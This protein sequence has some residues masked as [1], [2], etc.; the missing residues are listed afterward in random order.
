[1]HA[2]ACS[3]TDTDTRGDDRGRGREIGREIERA[4]EGVYTGPDKTTQKPWASPRA[5][6]VEQLRMMLPNEDAKKA[7]G[8]HHTGI[9]IAPPLQRWWLLFLAGRS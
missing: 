1:M 2:G 6:A 8:T 3:H 4:S 9:F 7:I 5:K